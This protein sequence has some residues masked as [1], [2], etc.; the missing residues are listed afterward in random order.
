MLDVTKPQKYNAYDAPHAD[1]REFLARI[2]AAGKGADLL[3]CPELSICGY[4]PEDL[5]YR[6]SFLDAVKAAA[7]KL[8]LNTA[9]GPGLLLGAPWRD[10]AKTHN[11]VLLLEGGGTLA[12]VAHVRAL[13]ADFYATSAYKWS[14]PHIGVVIADP[15]LLA[16]LH[17]DKLVPSPNDV[18][19]RFELG[20]LHGDFCV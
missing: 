4:P 10:G 6:P 13:G 14:G 5:V 2:E 9:S 3:V 20:T 16:D 15:H 11:A 12:F 7:E 8:A 19:E 18:P 1:L 17:P